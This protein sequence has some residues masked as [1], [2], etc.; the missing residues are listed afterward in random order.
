MESNKCMCNDYSQY[1][2]KMAPV[3]SMVQFRYNG[4]TRK[5]ESRVG[6]IIDKFANTF[7]CLERDYNNPNCQ[8][9]RNYK[10]EL[11][12]DTWVYTSEPA[13]TDYTLEES[14]DDKFDN[15]KIDKLLRTCEDLNS[16]VQLYV[17]NIE[18]LVAEIKKTK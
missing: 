6:L 2:I 1:D 10:Y 17:Y 11:C 13:Q 18:A 8:I 7:T 15:D 5:G 3:D 16:M 4:G 9:Y 12:Y 14:K